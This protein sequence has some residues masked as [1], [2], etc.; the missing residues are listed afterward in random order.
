MEKYVTSNRFKALF[1]ENKLPKVLRTLWA[2]QIIENSKTQPLADILSAS[3][4]FPQKHIS[5]NEEW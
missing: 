4:I 1:T 3:N 2:L 5:W